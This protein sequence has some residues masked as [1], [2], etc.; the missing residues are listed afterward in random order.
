MNT[1]Q[2][3]C[4]VDPAEVADYARLSSL[5]WDQEKPFWPLH[6][7]NDSRTRYTEEQITRATRR[8]EGG[9]GPKSAGH[10]VWR[11][12]LERVHRQTGGERAGERRHPGMQREP[13]HLA[14]QVI[15]R[16]LAGRRR[17]QG[18][19]LAARQQCGRRSSG[20]RADSSSPRPPPPWADS[21]SRRRAPAFPGPE[22]RGYRPRQRTMSWRKES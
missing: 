7:L 3:P 12:Y 9:V 20:R 22:L 4:S 5:W 17:L 15:E 14:R 10:R 21:C 6:R 19:H 16:L 2:Q 1:S 13:G 11:G 18:E 8:S